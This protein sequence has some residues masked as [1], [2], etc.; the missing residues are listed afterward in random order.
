MGVT[1]R[2]RI[3]KRNLRRLNVTLSTREKNLPTAEAVCESEALARQTY[4]TVFAALE[5]PDE[6]KVVTGQDINQRV[7]DDI[8]YG[9]QK[10]LQ[11]PKSS[12]SALK[13]QEMDL[14]MAAIQRLQSNKFA[15]HYKRDESREKRRQV[16]YA[17]SVNI[18]KRLDKRFELFYGIDFKEFISLPMAEQRALSRKMMQGEMDSLL[19]M[20]KVAHEKAYNVGF[21]KKMKLSLKNEMDRSQN[22]RAYASALKEKTIGKEHE[23]FE[24]KL[25]QNLDDSQADS[26]PFYVNEPSYMDEATPV[27][28]ATSPSLFHESD[29]RDD[30]S[31]PWT[32]WTPWKRAAI[33]TCVVSLVFC[34]ITMAYHDVKRQDEDGGFQGIYLG[35]TR[36]L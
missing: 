4:P 8:Q 21:M 30:K 34:L 6:R 15:I 31:N 11:N 23:E 5:Q 22:K 19:D 3:W 29:L 36:I 33:Y 9:M 25:T 10:V 32:K 14:Y 17:E 2:R 26:A 24:A 35:H 12:Q 28:D 27:I 20:Q 1:V 7:L 18:P 16:Q 13:A